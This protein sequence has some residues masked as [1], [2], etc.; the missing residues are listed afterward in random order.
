MPFFYLPLF[1]VIAAAYSATAFYFR[2]KLA[3]FAAEIADMFAK[4]LLHSIMATTP[5]SQYVEYSF[6]TGAL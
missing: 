6:T 1:L 4:C 3:T 2:M 5:H